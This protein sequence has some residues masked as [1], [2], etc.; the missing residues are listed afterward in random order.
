MRK[1]GF[2]VALTTVGALLGVAPAAAQP[3]PEVTAFCDAALAADKAVAKLESGGRPKQKD[4][5]A[6]E[7]ALGQA[8]STAPPEIATQIQAVVAAV[9]TGIQSGSDPFEDPAVEQ[10]FNA[11]QEY[12]YNSCGYRQLDVTGIE[13]EFQGLPRTLPAG[14]VAIK[15]T[16]TGAEWHELAIAR[17]KTKDSLKKIIGMSE[18]QQA[19]KIEE[20]GGTF[21]MQGQTS[22]TIAD[23]S[24]PGRYGVVCF[25]PVGATDAQAAGEAERK[26]AKSHADR[27]M[28]ATIRVE[29]A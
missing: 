22:Y 13:Y 8:E 29:A 19:K 2:L 16:D 12:R 28:L 14:K 23:M 5:Q 15:F 27:G 21:A 11:I 9:R 6:A 18:K 25:L 1:L 26:H 24:K 3:T 17:L 4:I 20:I 10:N 7:T